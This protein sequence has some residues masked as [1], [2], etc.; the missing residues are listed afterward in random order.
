MS[1]TSL[2]M[3]RRARHTQRFGGGVSMGRIR[4]W[5][6][7]DAGEQAVSEALLTRL[8]AQLLAPHLWTPKDTHAGEGFR[9]RFDSWS[10]CAGEASRSERPSP[11]AEERGADWRPCPVCRG[12][13][14]I[15]AEGVQQPCGVCAGLPWRQHWD[16]L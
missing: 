5:V 3:E 1:R 14:F 15:H 7:V 2:T 4:I 9:G 16:F 10:V 6:F 13:G 12:K 8:A 11:A